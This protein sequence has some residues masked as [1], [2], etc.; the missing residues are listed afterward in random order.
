MFFYCCKLHIFIHLTE[1]TRSTILFYRWSKSAY[2]NGCASNTNIEILFYILTEFDLP[3]SQFSVGDF[4]LEKKYSSLNRVSIVKFNFLGATWL[5]PNLFTVQKVTATDPAS[6]RQ[7]KASDHWIDLETFL[8]SLERV[9]LLTSL[10]RKLRPVWN[11][12]GEA[13]VRVWLAISNVLFI[14]L[15]LII[16]HKCHLFEGSNVTT[17]L[18]DGS[19]W[20]CW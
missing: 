20:I 5:Q 14:H 16:Q 4:I 17:Y 10:R 15:R 6:R 1:T 18:C 9:A 19:F 2:R 3:L 7:L 13:L 8:L 11:E 12:T